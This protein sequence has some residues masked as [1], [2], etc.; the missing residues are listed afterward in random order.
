MELSHL[1]YFVQ[2]AETGSFRR[3]AEMA[4]VSPPAMTKA[5]RKLEGVLGV[6][7]FERTTRRV[8]LTE[9][10]RTVLARARKALA[11]AA[12]IPR[13][14]E[15]MQKDVA[16]ELRIGAMEVF[17]VSILPRAIA[18]LVR[19]HP[20]VT[21]LTYEMHPET[22]QRQIADG[23]LDVAFTTGEPNSKGVGVEPLG[24]SPGRVVCGRRHP[25][26]RAGS[27]SDAALRDHPFVVPQ[28][29]Q[30]AD[31]PSLD[32]FP[33]QAHP[34]RVGA[35]I[36]LLQMMIELTIAGTYLGHFPEVSIQGH[37]ASGSLRALKG[38]RNLPRFRL[39]AWFRRGG[40]VKRSARA[41]IDTM[42]QTLAGG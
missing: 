30:R 14:L 40:P 32:Q 1:R 42:R 13:E 8:R 27:I 10:G 4:H 3:G 35:T 34:R 37:L 5:I 7:L 19:A 38:F 15:E 21:P 25:L 36:E 26:Y 11:E 2:V 16:G 17:S 33:D 9:E 24:D 6:E 22:I 18:A 28:L 20:K 12:A 23:L 31:L 29:F 39:G 41:L